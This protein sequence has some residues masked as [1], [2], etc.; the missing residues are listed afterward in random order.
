[1]I[2]S[3]ENQYLK[4]DINEKGAELFSIKSK[5][6]NVEYLWQGNPEFWGGR[7][8]LL[9]PICG[10]L[11]GGKYFYKGKEYQMPIHGFARLCDFKT[12][13]ISNEQIEFNITSNEQI[14]REYPYDFSFTVRYTLDD[15]QLK[16]EFIVENIGDKDLLFS[17]GGHPGFNVPFTNEE[18]FEDYY[19][20]FSKE[21]LVQYVFSDTCFYINK[22]K[23]YKL[24]NKK[25]PLS[26]NLFDND[27][28]FFET[29]TD[30]V[31]LKSN[32]SKN[33]IEVSYK[34]MT[35]LGL[36]HKPKTEAP[37]VCI[38]PWHGIPSTDGI[39]DDFESKQQLIKLSPNKK[40]ENSFSIKIIEV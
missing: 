9:F 38:E 3:I 20:E 24:N 35:C 4:V 19:L 36:W 21:E 30:K 23:A 27:A 6:T 37:Y 14:K 15:N 29:E 17:Y 39:I 40:Y 2:K 8:I 11:F 13:V 12:K 1:M 28:I 26:H 34:D 18:K 32:K 10:R 33:A 22:K 25:L 16:T 31:S 5:K 7:A